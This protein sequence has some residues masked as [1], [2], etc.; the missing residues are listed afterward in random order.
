MGSG[1]DFEILNIPG[2]M[3]MGDEYA[4][5]RIREEEFFEQFLSVFYDKVA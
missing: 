1:M 3:S 2:D 4:E 5:Y